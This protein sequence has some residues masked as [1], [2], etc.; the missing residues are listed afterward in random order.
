MSYSRAVPEGAEV[1][2]AQSVNAQVGECPVWCPVE[3]VLWWTDIV[4]RMVYRLDPSGGDVRSWSLPGRVGSFALRADGSLVA[5]MEGHFVGIDLAA[6]VVETI[7]TPEPGVHVNRMNDG[8]CDRSG[9]FFWAG[10]MHDRRPR[11]PRG[12][13]YR[14]A[15]DGAWT[16][17]G[18]GFHVSNGLAFSPDGARM[19]HSD[20]SASTVW[21]LDYDPDT[22]SV[23]NRRELLRLAPEDGRPD[24]AAVD[25][26][27]CY[28]SACFGGAQVLRITPEGEILER[29]PVPVSNPT[30]PAFGGPDLATLYVTSASEPCSPEELAERPLSG[31]VLAVELAVPGLAEARFAG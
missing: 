18:E 14:L 27:G 30:M 26:E 8:R 29:L 9:R 21:C 25:A 19:Y 10:T 3:G 11:E 17:E 24:G 16:R 13:L 6:G 15:P 23:G 28:W 12:A 22:G 2:C 31:A 5:A 7:A 20:S 4:S 1:R